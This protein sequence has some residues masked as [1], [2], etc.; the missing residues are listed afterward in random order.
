MATMTVRPQPPAEPVLAD[1][2]PGLGRLAYLAIYHVLPAVFFGMAAWSQGTGVVEYLTT[3]RPFDGTFDAVHFGADA[4]HRLL[5]FLFVGMVAVLF[6]LRRPARKRTTN[7]L[8]IIVAFLGTFSLTGVVIA[9]HTVDNFAVVIL[10]DGFL[11]AGTGTALV[12]LLQLG[13]NL[14]IT[15]AARSLVTAGL[16]GRVRHPLYAAEITAGIGALLPTL[17]VWTVVLFVA[18]VLFQLR[19]TFYE[20]AVL[21]SV[22]PDYAEYRARVPRLIPGWPTA[23]SPR[24]DA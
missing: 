19:R 16:Y 8:A 2:R 3:P 18:F 24:P 7:P 13:R 17:S 5:S 10:A 11:V 21:S 12:A 20:E 23:R 14:S 6:A 15:P 4:L 9:P 22:F 1:R